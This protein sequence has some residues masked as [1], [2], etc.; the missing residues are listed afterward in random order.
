MSDTSKQI[1]YK[2]IKSK[3]YKR[4]TISIK[5]S[6][7]IIVSAPRGVSNKKI[8]EFVNKNIKWIITNTIRLEGNL[9]TK[10]HTF[11]DGDTF[12]YFGVSYVLKINKVKD[13]TLT[14]LV[15]ILN[16]VE[17]DQIKK[18]LIITLS[19]EVNEEKYKDI[20]AE[21]YRR[22]TKRIVLIKFEEVPYF[23]K[24]KN[25][26]SNIKF[27]KSNSR[28]GS[29]SRIN[30]INFSFRLVMLPPQ[31]IEY[32]IY[33]ELIHIKE[34]NHGNNFYLELKKVC[35]NY[36]DLEFQIKQIEKSYNISLA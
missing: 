10:K 16:K 36:E 27:Q 24:M 5:R 28:W 1:N 11:L 34:K 3:K 14:K 19:T 2:I 25:S 17:I 30:N 4:I 9:S 21:F 12:L 15:N 20:I 7:Q 23:N 33:H 13:K 6:Q 26:V 32:V 8:D 18:E 29:C 31:C 22:E 35:P